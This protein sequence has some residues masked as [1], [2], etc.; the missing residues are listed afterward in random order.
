MGNII[1]AQNV[2]LT[3]VELAKA[4]ADFVDVRPYHFGTKLTFFVKDTTAVTGLASSSYIKQWVTNTDKDLKHEH[5][6]LVSVAL[7]KNYSVH[8]DTALVLTQRD[9]WPEKNVGFSFKIH[10]WALPDRSATSISVKGT[11]EYTALEPGEVLVEDI[12]HLSG[13]IEGLTS[14]EF[15]GNSIDLKPKVYGNGA[16]AYLTFNATV[17]NK[18]YQVAIQ[19]MQFLDNEGKLLDELYFGLSNNYNTNTRNRID[20]KN[21]VVIRMHYRKLK[22]KK[23]V[24][25]NTFG[26]GF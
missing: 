26:L 3:G 25:D 13:N 20:L 24:V 10:S 9:F 19:T 22:V 4:P 6:Q 11:I 21:T 5:Q 23:V 7:Y 15:I 2:E 14:L 17:T 8:K 18:A 1:N 16:E 12:T